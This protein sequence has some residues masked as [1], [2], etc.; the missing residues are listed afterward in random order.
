MAI[1][2]QVLD[3]N[4]FLVSADGSKPILYAPLQGVVMEVN[5]SYVERF[6]C[7]LEG[8]AEAAQVLGLDSSV[9]ERF[10][11]TPQVAER[12]LNPRWPDDF[13]PTSATIFLTHKCTLRCRYCYCH[14]GEG[15]N[16]PWPVFERSL[17]FTLDNASRLKR[18]LNL[19][20]H[21]GDVGAC[22]PLFQKCV[23]FIEDL[24]REREIK[25]VLSIGTN[26]YYTE[27]KAEY[28]AKH[29]G[30]ATVSID[31]IPQVHDRY[32]MTASAGPSLARIL[33]TIKVF[34]A[35]KVAYSIRMTVTQESLSRLPESVEFIC[36]NTQAVTIRAE[37][38]Y[39]RGRATHEGLSPPGPDAFLNGF[40]EAKNV[41]KRYGRL[42]TYSGARLGG[43]YGSFCSY[44]APT[45]GVTPEGNLTC[46]YEILHPTDPLR[47][48]F[49]YGRIPPDGSRIEVDKGR[50]AA[51]REWA[52]RRRE[53]CASCFCVF[54]CAGDCA[55]KVMDSG[56]TE[57]QESARCHIT[58]AL[59]YDMLSAV[60]SGE[61]PLQPAPPDLG[62][63]LGRAICTCVDCPE[64]GSSRG[65]APPQSNPGGAQ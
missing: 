7:A 39:S 41:A 9:I 4:V 43:V 6:R 62:C 8:D 24:C 29:I 10:I 48:P 36:R 63:G 45:F 22:W 42:L 18:N 53:S 56:L 33:G 60:L 52:K 23:A 57:D 61:N 25:P 32:R 2:W 40:R 51:I 50:V 47:E 15:R 54:A 16:M 65:S 30:T 49:F 5:Q 59:V 1:E 38:L 31:G 3:K 20:F 37:P 34:D 35:H 64:I 17:R 27:D 26:G 46:C 14:G 19:G 13:E 11:Q 21:G 44:P 28:I 55:A 58:R 12:R